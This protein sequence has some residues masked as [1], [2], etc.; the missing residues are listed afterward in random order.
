MKKLK[1]Y[2][3][4][5]ET[6]KLE[7][8]PLKNLEPQLEFLPPGSTVSVTAS[9]TKTL[10]DTWELSRR[11]TEM[12]MTPVPHLAARMINGPEHLQ[13]LIDQL[14]HLGTSELFLVGGDAPTPFGPFQDS[15]EVL[16]RILEM[17]HSIT[18]IGVS[19]YPDGHAMISNKDLSTALH[20]KQQ[21][22]GESNISGY[23]ATQ[24]CFDPTAVSQWL[25]AER[26]NGLTLPIH[27]GL[28]GAV[29]T[30]KLLKIGAR[31][32]VGTSLRFLKKNRGTVLKLLAPG[33]YNP[34]QLLDPLGPKLSGLGIE[35][36][37]VFTFNQIESTI[38]WR[39]K[40][41]NP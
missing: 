30:A 2:A 35:D 13:S 26:E 6:A 14:P 34:R 15:I 5:L 33:G 9:P 29:D 23:A 36:L 12:G 24:M 3:S 16:E 1:H 40:L 39:E 41:L 20:R 4:L 11:L 21:L 18:R 22:L 17:D 32:G 38:A 37:H 31:L 27:L 25:S 28:P 19:S 7:L 8:I 10:E